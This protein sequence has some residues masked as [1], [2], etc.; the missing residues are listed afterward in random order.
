MDANLLFTG[1]TPTAKLES[2][3]LAHNSRGKDSPAPLKE[4]GSSEPIYLYPVPR[5]LLHKLRLTQVT[6]C[7]N[8]S[9]PN[10]DYKHNK[11]LQDNPWGQPETNRTDNHQV[12]YLPRTCSVT[13]AVLRRSEPPQPNKDW[14][15]IPTGMKQSSEWCVEKI[16]KKYVR[17]KTKSNQLPID[18]VL[19]IQYSCSVFTTKVIVFCQSLNLI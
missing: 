18:L 2:H 6:F 13:A 10:T 12:P 4:C 15:W 7:V 3:K 14:L 17:L 5:K 19:H 16:H 8:T 11:A 9:S 1:L